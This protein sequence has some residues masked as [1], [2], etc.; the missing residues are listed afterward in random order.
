M[1]IKMA[2]EITALIQEWRTE[3]TKARQRAQGCE[4]RK[5]DL[6]ELRAE[7]FELC[8]DELAVRL[9]APEPPT[10]IAMSTVDP[11]TN[12]QL[13][14]RECDQLK[15][16]LTAVEAQLQEAKD[17]AEYW[18]LVSDGVKHSHL[19]PN[20]A[21]CRDPEH[22]SPCDR[23][24]AETAEAELD[25]LKASLRSLRDEIVEHAIR[26]R[27]AREMLGAEKARTLA[28]GELL[29]LTFCEERLASLVAVP[30]GT[31]EC[32]ST[33]FS[34]GPK[35]RHCFKCGKLAVEKGK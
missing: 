8:A 11:Y 27:A 26:I 35:S 25:T 29:G 22:R 23:C 20:S 32:G 12:E 17:D 15:A 2:N 24:R 16:Q 21:L 3:A 6:F 5:I 1:H 4:Q 13:A 10:E 34:Q 18:Q 9:K 30:Q 7:S 19:C 31:C 33:E 28:S 14:N